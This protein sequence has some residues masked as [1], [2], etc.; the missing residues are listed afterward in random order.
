[1]SHY[2]KYSFSVTV[3]PQA[4]TSQIESTGRNVLSCPDLMASDL[5]DWLEGD[6][7]TYLRKSI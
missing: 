7:L 4:R 1:M 2:I 5:G 6:V 3:E